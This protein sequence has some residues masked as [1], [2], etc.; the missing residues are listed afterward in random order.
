MWRE[1]SAAGSSSWDASARHHPP[2]KAVLVPEEERAHMFAYCEY[3]GHEQL[4]GFG[5]SSQ[6]FFMQRVRMQL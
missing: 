3:V 6:L 4:E 2:D 1:S 5:Y